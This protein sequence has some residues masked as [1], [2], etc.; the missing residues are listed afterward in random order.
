MGIVLPDTITITNINASVPVKITSERRRS[1]RASVGASGLLLRIPNSFNKVQFDNAW[2]W[3]TRWVHQLVETKLN[4]LQH[5]IPRQYK[6]GDFIVVRGIVYKI[7]ILTHSLKISKASILPNQV[8]QLKIGEDYDAEQAS[9][10]VRKLIAGL[11]S[12][13]HLAPLAARVAELNKQ[14]FNVRFNEVKI[15]HTHSRWGSCSTTGTIRLSSRLLLAPPD[16]IDYV[17][18]HEL[19]HLIE[20]NHSNKFW[21]LVETAMPNYQ[22]KEKWLKENNYVCRF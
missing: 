3:F 17:I 14:H 16:V 18:I 9:V 22:E 8:I 2:L 5:L 11:M 21:K 20:F 13:V 10:I 4:I 1:L 6:H 19:S 12:K 7:V 15:P